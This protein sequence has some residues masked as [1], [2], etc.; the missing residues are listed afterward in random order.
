MSRRSR[1][2]ED[3]AARSLDSGG[4]PRRETELLGF[5]DRIRSRVLTF[6]ERRG[7]RLGRRLT[8]ALLVVPDIL[9]LLIRIVLDPSVPRETR[10]VVGGG[11]AYFLLPLDVVPEILVG[12]PGYVED[13][14]VASTVLAFAFGD[15]LER[16]AERYWSGSDGLRRVLGDI[17]ETSSRLLGVDVERRVETVVARLLRSRGGPSDAS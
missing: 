7:S 1:S 17:A 11:L 8:E 9:L 10:A 16:R 14:L 2:R 6:V 5:Y 4:S 3:V 12:P 15:D 13:L